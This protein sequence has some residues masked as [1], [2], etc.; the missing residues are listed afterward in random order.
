MALSD[1][2]IRKAW[3][4]PKPFKLAD[5]VG[6]FALARP[7][8][9]GLWHRNYR[10]LELCRTHG[11]V[12]PHQQPVFRSRSLGKCLQRE[13]RPKIVF[14][15]KRFCARVERCNPGSDC[16]VRINNLHELLG[17]QIRLSVMTD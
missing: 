11:N 2:W 16:F 14:L 3:P 5:A 7:S 4:S 12:L 8:G 17:V 10:H 6:L 9:S 13:A 1:L 15:D